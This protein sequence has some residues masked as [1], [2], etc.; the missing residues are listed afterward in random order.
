M[1][2]VTKLDTI[3]I[4]KDIGLNHLEI[5]SPLQLITDCKILFHYLDT[6]LK[7]RSQMKI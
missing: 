3:A 7:V 1:D 5:I 2:F 6:H 4:E